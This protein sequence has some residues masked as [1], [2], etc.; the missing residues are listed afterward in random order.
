LQKDTANIVRVKSF[1]EFDPRFEMAS[2]LSWGGERLGLRPGRELNG[3]GTRIGIVDSGCDATHAL[4]QHVKRGT[5]LNPSADPGQWGDDEIGHG[6]HC[7]GIIGARSDGVMPASGIAPESEIYAY[8]VFPDG[9][10]FTLGKA[11]DSAINDGVDILNLSLGCAQASPFLTEKLERARQ[12]GIAS[13]VAAGNSGADV[14]FPASLSSVV[15]VSALG[16]SPVVPSDSISAQSFSPA[17][18]TPD[19][20][21]SP[22]FTCF[23]PSIDLIAPG[24]GIIS[25]VPQ[26]GL[27]VMDGTS[28][29][30]PHVTEVRSSPV[31]A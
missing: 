9:S 14:M 18:A 29:A 27:K 4:L 21:F 8:K 5:N 13:I 31:G 15:A 10:F 20:F 30:A 1:K 16:Y 11:I 22:L 28:M 25:T 24:V 3:G 7:A 6:T 23:G 26:G 19:G 17:L 2:S 12:A